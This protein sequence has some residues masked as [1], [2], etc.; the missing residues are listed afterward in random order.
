VLREENRPDACE[1]E[2]IEQRRLFRR[3]RRSPQRTVMQGKP[4]LTKGDEL[5]LHQIAWNSRIGRYPLSR[6]PHRPMRLE[7]REHAV[8]VGA[9]PLSA[10]WSDL[11]RSLSIVLLG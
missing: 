11:P 5:D 2:L 7:H 1:R 8:A 10:L 3:S 4:F 6:I 9:H